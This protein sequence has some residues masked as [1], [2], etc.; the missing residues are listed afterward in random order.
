MAARATRYHFAVEKVNFLRLRNAL[1]CLGIL[2]R[3]RHSECLVEL[4][5]GGQPMRFSTGKMARLADGAVVAKCGH[6]ATLV[7]AVS[8]EESKSSSGQGLLLQVDYKEK[9]AA[10]GQ[11]PRSFARRDIGAS[12]RD[13]LISRRIDRSLRPLFPKGYSCATQVTGSLWAADGCYDPDIAAMNG[14]S[15]ALAVSSIPWHGPIG[16]VRVGESNGEFV[17]NPSWSQLATS[18]LNVVVACSESKVVMV[19]AFANEVTPDRFCESLR[20]GYKECQPIVQA[21][22]ELQKQA[23]TVKRPFTFLPTPVEVL[24]AVQSLL[25]EPLEEIFSNFSFSKQERDKEMFSVRDSCLVAVQEQFPDVNAQVIADAVLTVT[26]S[27][28]RK[29]ILEKAQRCDGRSFDALRPIKCEVDLFK[30]LHGSSLFQRGETQVFCTATLGSLRSAKH[31]DAATEGVGDD[32]ERSFIL[33]YEFPPF[34]I[35]ETG[36]VGGYTRREV[37][38]GNLA[39]K[40]LEPVVPKD[41]PFAIRLTSQVLESNGSSSIATACAGSLAL[42]DAGV[43]ISRPVAGVAC[44]LVTSTDSEDPNKPDIE[45]YQLMTDILGI[46]DFMGDMD[47]KL[48][49]SRKGITALQADFKIPGV[50]LHMVEEAIHKATEDRMKVLD[51]I[52]E[53]QSKPRDIRKENAPA[54]GSVCL[55]ESK[56]RKLVGVAGLTI[57]Q[58]QE[59]TGA[60]ISRVGEEQF[61]VF[62]PNAKVLQET[63]AKIEELTAEEEFWTEDLEVGEKYSATIVEVRDYGVMVELLPDTPNVLL[64]VSEM[65][66]RRIRN[67]KELNMKVGD[68]VDVKYLGRHDRS[69]R[70]EISRKALLPKTT[71]GGLKKTTVS[72]EDMTP[73]E[74]I[75]TFLK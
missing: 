68:T 64:H 7:T 20:F 17:V 45:R 38:H 59:E 28:F 3:S 14:A 46:E 50:P 42:L 25:V 8:E 53:C 13:I 15:A 70:L 1:K 44:G 33:H 2:C 43:P 31:S 18:E 5:V 27:V 74:F 56:S 9:A 49:G 54:L 4:E 34:C 72:E 16:V 61:S 55:K 63:M 29:N 19:E 71:A 21:L 23:G 35:N 22:H 52:E 30:P 47:F 48:A 58:L 41:Y 69:G 11:F 40:A 36:R 65:D 62:A 73:E 26:K 32:K 57:R 37:G 51:V 60:T 10:G 75:A 6:N 66:H 67:P 24:E 39:E 12:D